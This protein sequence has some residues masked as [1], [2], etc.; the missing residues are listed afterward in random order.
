[1][2]LEIL[3]ALCN[4]FNIPSWA[5]S[6]LQQAHDQLATISDRDSIRYSVAQHAYQELLENHQDLAILAMAYDNVAI[7]TA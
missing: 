2:I 5:A 6:T 1:M 7:A 4:Q 3:L